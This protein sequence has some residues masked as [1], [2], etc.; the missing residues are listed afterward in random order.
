MKNPFLI[1]DK[2]GNSHISS[3]CSL[4]KMVIAK[5]PVAGIDDTIN[6]K[7]VSE[8][9]SIAVV[10]KKVKEILTQK[11]LKLKNEIYDK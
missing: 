10:R 3:N 6:G 11:M 2:N 5:A 8:I 9:F 1:I 4:N 7:P